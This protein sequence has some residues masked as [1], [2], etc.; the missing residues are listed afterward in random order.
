MNRQI[1]RDG[2]KVMFVAAVL[3]ALAPAV[4]MAADSPMAT[5]HAFFDAFN[6]GDTRAAAATN[7]DGVSIID[8]VPPHAWRGPGSFQAWLGDLAN[9]SAANGQ[10]EMQAVVG[11]TVRSQ[12]EGDTAYAVVEASLTYRLR[13]E[14]M[15]EPA[16]IAFALREVGGDWKINSWAWTGGVP[17]PVV[18]MK[19]R[20]AARPHH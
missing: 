4:A 10:T 8:E 2:R 5:V 1:K 15:I 20:R 9:D 12:A 18:P 19:A 3:A 6:R 17:H 16:Q 7:T 13:G 14:R 11:R